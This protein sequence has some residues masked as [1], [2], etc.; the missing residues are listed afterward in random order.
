MKWQVFSTEEKFLDEVCEMFDRLAVDLEKLRTK[1]GLETEEEEAGAELLE[2]AAY[3]EQL[4]CESGSDAKPHDGIGSAVWQVQHSEG[5]VEG[6]SEW[7]EQAATPGAPQRKELLELFANN[8]ERTT[9]KQ[10]Q[11]AVKRCLHKYHNA[12]IDPG[13]AVRDY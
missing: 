4:E 5:M 7:D 11:I 6:R 12:E 2:P 8:I 13:E 9:T 10:M 1:L 3:V